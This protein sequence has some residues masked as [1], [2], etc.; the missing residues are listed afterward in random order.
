MNWPEQIKIPSRIG[1]GAYKYSNGNPCCA[2]GHIEE[3]GVY[4]LQRTIY[5]S[6][7]IKL[8]QKLHTLGKLTRHISININFESVEKVNDILESKN[9]RELYLLTWAKMGYTEG[10]PSNVLK[11]LALPEIQEVRIIESKPSDHENK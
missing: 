4:D 1:I 7:Y 10:M 2:M 6:L 3:N 5:R 8:A 9:R 11:L